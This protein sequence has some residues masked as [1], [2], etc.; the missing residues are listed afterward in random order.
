MSR[1]VSSTAVN[2]GSRAGSLSLG[3]SDG[4]MQTYHAPMSQT[5]TTVDYDMQ[6]STLHTTGEDTLR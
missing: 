4:G 6:V 1:R 3:E 5:F 2:F